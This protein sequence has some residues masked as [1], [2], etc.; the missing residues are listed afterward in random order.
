MSDWRVSPVFKL[1]ESKPI[2]GA[3][4]YSVDKSSNIWSYIRRGRQLKQTLSPG[5]YYQVSLMHD[6][7][8]R[9]THDVHTLVAKAFIPNPDPI[10]NTY[11][12]HIDRNPHNKAYTN[13]RWVTPSQSGMN[14]K[15]FTTTGAKG[16][17]KRG[18]RYKAAI[19][20]PQRQ[21]TL[22]IGNFATEQA[23]R[24]AYNA[25]ALELRGEFA[26]L[27]PIDS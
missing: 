27:N 22:C 15:G 13:L 18:Q 9:Y 8:K 1:V 26:V 12:D 10:N 4:R 16:V 7:G 11:A 25:K 20:I 5:G 23:A 6:D 2:A 14:K 3:K 19:W 21:K 17:H 24:L